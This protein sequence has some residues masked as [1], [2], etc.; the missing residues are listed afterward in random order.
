MKSIVVHDGPPEH[1]LALTSLVSGLH[2]TYGFH[3][4]TWITSQKN[5]VFFRSIKGVKVKAFTDTFDREHVYDIAISLGQDGNSLIFMRHV[6]AK[7]YFGVYSAD[8]APTNLQFE[9]S[10]SENPADAQRAI[11]IIHGH[12]ES[13]QNIFQVFFMMAGLSWKG[14]GYGF[15]YFPRVKEKRRIPG[16]AIGND[17]VREYVK[18]NL[19]VVEN[20]LWHIPIKQDPMKQFDEVNKVGSVIT[21][22]PFVMH[23]GVALRKHVEFLIYEP[24]N[25]RSEFFGKGVCHLVPD[26]LAGP[27]PTNE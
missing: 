24:P 26:H 22:N 15:R 3:E 27:E 21:D 18:G 23:V 6:L 8:N 19:E 11:Q 2:R 13:K 1:A 4:I 12:K 16:I 10:G 9:V 5:C 17:S 20:K 14:D 25:M 7:R